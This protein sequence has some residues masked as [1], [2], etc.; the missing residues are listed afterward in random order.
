[1]MQVIDSARFSLHIEFD[2]ACYPKLTKKNFKQL[3][4][5]IRTAILGKYLTY[6]IL[7]EKDVV[8]YPDDVRVSLE[9]HS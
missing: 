7:G 4:Q 8:C 3:E 2:S 9:H 5:D 1:M 6:D